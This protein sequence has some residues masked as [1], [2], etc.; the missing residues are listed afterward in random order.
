[1]WKRVE[2]GLGKRTVI[3]AQSRNYPYSGGE[4]CSFKLMD[5]EATSPFLMKLLKLLGTF[6]AGFYQTCQFISSKGEKEYDNQ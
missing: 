6:K 2:K 4:Y 5:R 3:P 1:M